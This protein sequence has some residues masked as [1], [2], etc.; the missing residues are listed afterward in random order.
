MLSSNQEMSG[1]LNTYRL[2]K[3]EHTP[4]ESNSEA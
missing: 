3:R 2:E 1:L 4:G